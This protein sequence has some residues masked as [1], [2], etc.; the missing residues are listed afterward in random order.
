[1]SDTQKNRVV[2]TGVGPVTSIG[3]GREEFW[4]NLL[5]NE[6]NI[7]P[8]PEIFENGYSFK[9]KFYV[10]FPEYTMEEFGFKSRMNMLT[11]QT[12][13]LAL[14]GTKLAFEDAGIDEESIRESA[15]ASR[16]SVVLGN[17]I[18][19]LKAGFEAFAA[20]TMPE[21]KEFFDQYNMSPRFNRMVIPSV[22]PDSPACWISIHYGLTGETYTLNTSCASGTYA[23]GEAYRKIHHGLADM[24]VSG[25]VECL[26]DPSGTVMRGFDTLGTLSR[27]EDGF[28]LPFSKQRSGFLFAEGGG[29]ILIL[30]RLDKAL[31]RGADIY[32][33]IAG[34]DSCSDAYNLVQIEPTGK[35]IKKMINGLKGQMKIDY[36]NAHGTATT[37]ND[38]FEQQMIKD[39]FGKKSDQPLVNSTKGTLGHSIGAS[40]AIEAAVTAMSI[41]YGK[42]HENVSHDNFE[43][44]NLANE[45]CDTDVNTAMSAS[46]G[47]GGHNA[48]L[49]M[50]KWKD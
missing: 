49:L 38:E 28:P 18:C 12:S 40:G 4:T 26:K 14:I 8:I 50:K 22:M 39:L 7:Q 20:H 17:G 21:N 32:A 31:E 47:F 9:S 33:E 44:L 2:I 16:S 1:M 25:G 27:S 19:T 5:K 45:T 13:R 36:F 3:T 41:K 11:E 48:A 29:C 30:E 34:Y 43:N 15:L 23:V 24:V 46:Y 35:Y 42:V 6:S 37:L 10:P